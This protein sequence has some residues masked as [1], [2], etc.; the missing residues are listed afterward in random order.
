MNI[1]PPDE[2][3]TVRQIAEAVQREAAPDKPI[4]FT[5]GNKGWVGDVPR[6]QYSIE[7]LKKLGWYPKLTS[8]QAVE[9]A[10]GE[11]YSEFSAKSSL[12]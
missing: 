1:G 8:T 3:A 4:R 12:H 11:I 5:G 7:K 10:V 2:G 6:F 9:R